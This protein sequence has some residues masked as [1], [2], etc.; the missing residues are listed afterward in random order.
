MPFSAPSSAA[1]RP[2]S[3]RQLLKSAYPAV[4][5][6][7]P[8]ATVVLGGLAGNDFQ[9]LEGVYQAGG[10]GSFDAVGVHTSPAG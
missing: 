1:T 6:A 2:A 8:S 3:A 4:K 9:L 7:D 5:A 10:K